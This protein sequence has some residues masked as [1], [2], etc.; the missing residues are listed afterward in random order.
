MPHLL[1][2]GATGSGKSVFVNAVIMSILFKKT[3]DEVRF[4]MIDPKMLEL[5]VYDGIPH[6]LL[7]VVTDPKKATLALRW[8]VDEMERRYHLLS[9]LGVRHID[10]YNAK[11]NAAKER[12][13]VL[14]R[15]SGDEDLRGEACEKLPYIV[16]IVD[17]LADLMMTASKDVE[18]SI[19]R[20]AQK[21]RAAGVHLML[22]TQRPSVDVLTGVIKANF[23]TRV[24]F[25]VAARA[26]SRTILDSIGAEN[27]L[28]NGD[29]LYQ[30]AGGN[31]TRVHGAY[32][33][34]DEIDAV[35]SF[36]KAQG[37]PIYHEEI[38]EEPEESLGFEAEEE[39]RDDMYDSAVALVSETQTASISMIQRRLRVGYN[40]AARMIECMEV[41]GIVGPPDGSR[42]REVFSHSTVP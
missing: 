20:L 4:I 39:P 31:L 19:M 42:G 26:D 16:I 7:P 30:T 8:A 14:R 10:G 40:R 2:A 21:A 32:V 1:V 24:A 23:P 34:E 3:P 22:A 36:L 28:G 6:L 18:S 38:L 37:E 35:V 5:S 17:E 29:M 27:L 13:E 11:V 15:P 41:E 9:D 25:Q 33:T 12:G